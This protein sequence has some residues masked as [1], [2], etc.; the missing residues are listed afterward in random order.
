MSRSVYITRLAKFLPNEPVANEEIEDVLGKINGKA[1]R[2]KSIILR[3]NQIKTRY[4]AI[5]RQ[6]NERV[7][8][9]FPRKPLAWY[10]PYQWPAVGTAII[11]VLIVVGAVVRRRYANRPLNNIG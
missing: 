2:A 7:I 9:V 10:A 11:I 6:G 5:D 8:K 1:S 3:S 4:Y